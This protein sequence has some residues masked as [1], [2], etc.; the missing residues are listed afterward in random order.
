MLVVFM[1]SKYILAFLVYFQFLFFC[2][3]GS[4]S[5]LAGSRTSG[6]SKVCSWR[7]LSFHALVQQLTVLYSHAERRALLTSDAISVLQGHGL[8]YAS[9]CQSSTRLLECVVP[10][11]EAEHTKSVWDMI[12]AG[13][14]RSLLPLLTPAIAPFV[15][16]VTE[17]LSAMVD[18]RVFQSSN[19]RA[20]FDAD[21]LE[22][23][24][25]ILDVQFA[26]QAMDKPKVPEVAAAVVIVSLLYMPG[27][28]N[29]LFFFLS[30]EPRRASGLVSIRRPQI[31][32]SRS[33]RAN[34]CS[35]DSSLR[36]Q[37]ADFLQSKLDEEKRGVDKSTGVYHPPCS[38]RGSRSEPFWTFGLACRL[39]SGVFSERAYLNNLRKGKVRITDFER[40]AIRVIAEA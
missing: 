22:T 17:K 15:G 3:V 39:P 28:S 36:N 23:V 34:V 16:L 10:V 25:L 37:L 6:Q 2:A 1:P 12:E 26:A 13:P 40:S 29:N 38:R 24:P 8:S 4:L 5:P 33:V 32:A 7:P 11:V 35:L 21:F 30:I 31:P 27:V 19:R 14:H 9:Q 18:L 20:M